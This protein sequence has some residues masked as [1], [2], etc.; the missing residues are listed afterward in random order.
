MVGT[1]LY[2][3]NLESNKQTQRI[4]LVT[5]IYPAIWLDTE[6][7]YLFS[8][9]FACKFQ[10]D[11]IQLKLPNFTFQTKFHS[12]ESEFGICCQI[13]AKFAAEYKSISI[14]RNINRDLSSVIWIRL[15]QIHLYIENSPWNPNLASSVNS[16]DLLHL[17]LAQWNWIIELV[18]LNTKL[19]RKFQIPPTNTSEF[20][21]IT[22]IRLLFDFNQPASWSKSPLAS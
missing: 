11:Q 1:L 13:E 2:P 9:L 6:S 8:Y 17:E 7:R 3:S 12:S 22:R 16:A 19:T 21:Y 10:Y 5:N 4:V 18:D 20:P 14:R 15:N